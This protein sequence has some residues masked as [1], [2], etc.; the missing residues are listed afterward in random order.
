MPFQISF[1]QI[2]FQIT[3]YSTIE[4]VKFLDLFPLHPILQILFHPQ[5]FQNNEIVKKM[6]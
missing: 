3:S 6:S 1:P 5:V 4:R 2:L